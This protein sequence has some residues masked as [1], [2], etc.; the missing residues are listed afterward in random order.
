MNSKHLFE[1][2][3]SR[4]D[5]IDSTIKEYF[6]VM[7]DSNRFIEAIDNITQKQSYMIDGIY[8]FFPDWNSYDKN[9]HFYGVQFAI[10]YPPEEDDILTVSE[11]VCYQYVR[12]ACDKYLQLHPEFQELIESYLE[13]VE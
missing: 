13:R 7:Y 3:L 11:E 1:R 5:D 10:A 4:T 2:P 6:D 12:L 8:C 9:E